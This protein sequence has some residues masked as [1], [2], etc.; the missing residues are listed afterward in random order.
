M[1]Q[2]TQVIPEG[3]N[4]INSGKI[5]GINA[6]SLKDSEGLNFAVPL[7]PVC[8]AISLLRENKNPSPPKL[9][10]SFATDNVHEMYLTIAG[11]RYGKLPMD[12]RLETWL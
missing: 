9:P 11:N 12:C 5:V 10:I 3:T 4:R 2:L 1:Q 8:R 7:P 6:M